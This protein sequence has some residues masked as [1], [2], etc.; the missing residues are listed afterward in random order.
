[1]CQ[2]HKRDVLVNKQISLRGCLSRINYNL[3]KTR[4]KKLSQI[5]KPDFLVNEHTS[6]RDSLNHISDNLLKAKWYFLATISALGISYKYICMH[7][8]LQNPNNFPFLLFLVFLTGDVILWLIGEYILSHG[9]LFRY[10]QSTLAGIEY[11]IYND[12]KNGLEE[13][14]K[15]KFLDLIKDKRKFINPEKDK[16]FFFDYILPD[17][18]V[19]MYWASF[20][21]III[22]GMV[23]YYVY[24]I[25]NKWNNFGVILSLVVFVSSCF[26]WKLWDY[27]IYKTRN[28]ISLFC[29]FKIIVKVPDEKEFFSFPFMNE[30]P[31]LRTILL[32]VILL[33]VYYK[34]GFDFIKTINSPLLLLPIII[35]FW[36]VIFGLLVYFLHNFYRLISLEEWKNM[37]PDT[38]LLKEE[39]KL[40][41][42]VWGKYNLRKRFSWAFWLLF[43]SI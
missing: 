13:Q 6:L 20:W 8:E 22:N 10:V 14:E 42:K 19:P 29:D 23:A 2:I 24:R 28:F 41:V 33:G 35:Y 40:E 39:N 17:Q 37:S 16:K 7:K 26:V 4:G 27:H 34:L 11:Y 12:P 21:V 43:Y 5:N 1:M 25:L 30:K 31:V 38:T 18:F 9:F 32:L 3:L 36:P 15:R